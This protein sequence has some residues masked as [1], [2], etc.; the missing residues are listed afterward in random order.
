MANKQ[1]ELRIQKYKQEPMR[2]LALQDKNQKS[3]EKSASGGAFAVLARNVLLMQGIV[4]GVSLST[5]G[6]AYYRRVT[7]LQEL[8]EI[9]G[10]KYVQSDTNGIFRDVESALKENKCTLFCGLPCQV[11]ALK[12]YLDKRK[13]NM[14]MLLTCDLIC[15]GVT[16]PDLLTMY[17]E[18]LEN[19]KRAKSNSL[20]YIF[21]SKSYKWGLYYLYEYTD[22]RDRRRVVQGPSNDDPYCRGYLGG[23]L[24]RERCYSCSFAC[25]ERVGDYTLGDYWGIEKAHPDFYSEKGVSLVLINSKK[26]QSFFE[27]NCSADC[28]WIDSSFEKASAENANLRRPSSKTEEGIILAQRVASA[29]KN[30]DA[31][32]IFSKLL[33]E[34]GF[35]AAVRRMLPKSILRILGKEFY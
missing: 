24:F 9:Q 11:Y 23:Q 25:K 28:I 27:E 26:G 2:I 16:D 13:V 35:K 10:S 6:V 32:L 14:D 21:R 8:P 5:K 34:P 19:R 18:W 7:S 22:R 15:H 17:F 29:Q 1:A 12:A 31:D 33:I 3:L 30:N 4:F 20:K